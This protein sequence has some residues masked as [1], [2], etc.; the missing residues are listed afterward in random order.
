MVTLLIENERGTWESSAS[1]V[2]SNMS[3]QASSQAFLTRVPV[4]LGD[5]NDL[6]AD[7]NQ[8]RNYLL[9]SGLLGDYS[10]VWG[11][12]TVRLNKDRFIFLAL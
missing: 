8:L 11:E 2:I 10:G 6:C 3:S 5:I 4:K 7:S 12:G 1:A 9:E